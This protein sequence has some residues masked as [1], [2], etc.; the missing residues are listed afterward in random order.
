MATP[1]GFGAADFPKVVMLPEV[2]FDAADGRPDNTGHGLAVVPRVSM[3]PEV[4]F[5]AR[6]PADAGR[7]AGQLESTSQYLG[8][9]DND[10]SLVPRPPPSGSAVRLALY[11]AE[12]ATPTE[13]E[14][15]I[16]EAVR[17]LESKGIRAIVVAK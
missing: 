3:L 1:D 8:P 13:F 11:P 14:A 4:E 10:G 15:A 6:N 9:Y 7:P 12:G 5:D 2:V 16:T 17:T